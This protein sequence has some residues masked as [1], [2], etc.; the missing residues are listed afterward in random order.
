MVGRLAAL[1][2]FN[3][4]YEGARLRYKLKRLRWELKYA[5]QRA[6][7]GYDDVAVFECFDSF[8]KWIIP[9][10]KDFRKTYSG[11]W[12]KDFDE[13]KQ[14]PICYTAEEQDA[15]LDEMIMHFEMADEDWYY[16]QKETF[17][18]NEMYDKMEYHKNKALKMFSKY[19]WNLWD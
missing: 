18:Y 14:E 10:L 13:E 17:E 15:I 5:W 7:R 3:K 1:K 9:V 2:D 12:V 16:N 8:L 19:F 4:N 11:M 6:W